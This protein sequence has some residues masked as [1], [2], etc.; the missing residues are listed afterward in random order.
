MCP[1]PP[2]PHPPLA[3]SSSSLTKGLLSASLR[4]TNDLNPQAGHAKD[5]PLDTKGTHCTVTRQPLWTR[6]PISG[7]TS[8]AGRWGQNPKSLCFAAR[9]G[10]GFS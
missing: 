2:A 10:Q 1:F 3:L 4:D 7:Q 5:R 6:T 9:T 8:W